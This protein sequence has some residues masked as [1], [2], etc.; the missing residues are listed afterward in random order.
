MSRTPS[1]L[2]TVFLAGCLPELTPPPLVDN[3]TDDWDEDGYTEEDGDCDDQN[4]A[5]H[6][7]RLERCDGV[8]NN[9]DDE[10]DGPL[11]VDRITWYADADGD[12]FGD[13]ATGEKA[14]EQPDNLVDVGGDCDDTNPDLNPTTEWYADN[15]RDGHGDPAV[16]ATQCRA[17]NF[18]VSTADDCDDTNP[19]AVPD[20][21]WFRDVDK[22]GFG[23][24]SITLTQCLQPAGYVPNDEDCD[25]AD[26]GA[27]PNGLWFPDAD[28]DGYGAPGDEIVS[29]LRPEGRV[30]NSDDCDDSDANVSPEL[31][32]YR[33]NDS[34]GFGVTNDTIA[35]CRQPIGYVSQPDDCLDADFDINPNTVWYLDEDEDGYGTNASTLVQCEQ[36][37]GYASD[38][39]DCDDSDP[40]LFP[41]TSWYLDADADG[42]GLSSDSVQQCLPPDGRVREAGDCDD[43]NASLSP[44]TSWFADADGDGAGTASKEQVQCVQ[45]DGYVMSSDDCDDARAELTPSTVW[46]LDADADGFGT[47]ATTQVQCDVLEGYALTDDDCDDTNADLT[48]NTEWY[49]D[50]D[51]DGF[52]AGDALIQ[53]EQPDGY[54]LPNGDC[55]PDNDAVA[56]SAWYADTDA[57]TFGDPDALTYAC[58]QPD[59]TVSNSA[60]C[61]DTSAEITPNTTWF[62]DA[63]GDGYG[64]DDGDNPVQCEAPD[65]HAPQ[66]GDC[67]DTNAAIHPATEWY[68]DNDGDGFGV[69][70][71]NVVCE[72]PDNHVLYNGDCDDGN[73]TVVPDPWYSDLDQDTH[74]DLSTLRYA[75]SQPN[76]LVSSSDDCNDEDP[77]VFTGAP[78]VCE[79]E[80]DQDCDGF[81]VDC[82]LEGNLTD[83]RAVISGVQGTGFGTA[84]LATGERSLWV[85]APAADTGAGAVYLLDLPTEPGAT[86][87]DAH[88]VYTL[89]G[90]AGSRTGAALAQRSSTELF[91]TAPDWNRAG[92]PKG[93]LVLW[94]DLSGTEGTLNG[95]ASMWFGR[96]D[97]ELVGATLL[98]PGDVDG[99]GTEDLIVGLPAVG[100]LALL[101]D[102]TAGGNATIA[103]LTVFPGTGSLGASLAAAGDLNGDGR[104]DFFVGAPDD[105]GGSGLVRLLVDLHSPVSLEDNTGWSLTGPTD[106]RAG[107]RLATGDV[108]GDD[109]LDLLI[110]APG[111]GSAPGRLGWMTTP[112]TLE[113]TALWTDLDASLEGEASDRAVSVM[114]VLPDIDK[115]GADDVMLTRGST[116]DFIP[117]G[118]R[119]GTLALRATTYPIAAGSLSLEGA[120]LT[121][122]DLTSDG[123]LERVVGL[124]SEDAVYLLGGG[125]LQE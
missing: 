21:V 25:D 117:G 69:G 89:Y 39:E 75:C 46:Y 81:D 30:D 52:G 63:D 123:Y 7:N 97:G 66:D 48:P 90:T 121:S 105:S 83:A 14:C 1:L 85:S 92:G 22:D 99:D 61:D 31:L 111:T 10:I 119:S 12:G 118:V 11:S 82:L 86:T 58:D 33:D 73:D 43:T 40:T 9:C 116:L 104:A 36:P 59:G 45:P 109:T 108:D 79:D 100:A 8:D 96:S 50:A 51:L 42:Y 101:T 35:Q 38:A 113:G 78:E 110:G 70:P 20:A 3:P 125:V 124:P 103:D 24:P 17:P 5:I 68:L 32:W 67:D 13:T 44:E 54:V 57:D 28:G 26:A 27:Y 2:L 106:G 60:D 98:T 95:G 55:Q 56:P 29:C 19:D 23:N 122:T 47:S 53:C 84:L 18:Y 94:S 4:N 91:L 37:D 88:T 93:A 72:Q 62:N 49:E 74:G 64:V 76:G 71:A 6:P 80:T 34:D 41:G 102:D 107:A 16:T 112:L 65:A 120:Q 114:S 15:D 115:D 77:A 87:A